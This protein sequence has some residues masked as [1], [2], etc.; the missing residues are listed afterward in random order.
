[1]NRRKF[2]KLL[3]SAGTSTAAFAACS[4]YMQEALAQSNVVNTLL[5]ASCPSPK[6]SLKDIEHVILFMQENRSFDHYFGTLRGVRGFG[7]PRPLLLQNG[8]QVWEQPIKAGT[9]QT[10][11][12]YH[13]VGTVQL[14][15]E[16]GAA[17]IDSETTAEAGRAF[18]Q[19]P[20]HGHSDSV[21]AW[22]CGR[23]DGWVPAKNVVTLAHYVEQDL[24]LYF[25]LAK[26]FTVCDANFCSHNGG[27]DSNRSFYYTGT[28]MGRND[29]SY[30]SGN[31]NAASAPNWPSYP[32]RLETLGVDWRFYQDGLHWT[33][34]RPFDG[35]YGDNTLEYFQQ[36]QDNTTS[37]FKKNQSINSVLRTSADV[38]SR[39]EQDIIDAKLPA[40]SWIVAPEAFS[41]H[42]TFPPHLGEYYLNEILRCLAANPEVWRKTVLITT[43]DEN[44][45]FFDHVPPP[46]PPLNANQGL[47]SSGIR[48]VAAPDGASSA[49]FD[50]D[51]DIEN[52]IDALSAP[53][54]MGAR[55]P[56]LVISP[57]STGGRVCSEVF[58]HTSSI[59]FVEAWLAAKGVPVDQQPYE[60]I[61]MWRMA[62]AGD[63][64]SAL[65]FNQDPAPDMTA[66]VPPLTTAEIF[67]D[68]QKKV[69][70][71]WAWTTELVPGTIGPSPDN[72][73]TVVASKQETAQVEL[74]PLGYEFQVYSAFVIPTGG[75]AERLQFTFRNAGQLGVPYS[76]YVYSSDAKPRFYTVEGVEQG[77]DPITLSDSMD[78]GGGAYHYVVHAPNGYLA[79][80][81]GNRS[82]P[83]QALFPEVSA[84]HALDDAKTAQVALT[85]WPSANGALKLIDAY[86]GNNQNLPAGTQIASIAT[87]D[88]WYDLALVDASGQ[89]DFLR[90]YSGHFE[91]GKISKTDPAIGKVYD[92]TTY[93]YQQPGMT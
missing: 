17:P 66:L 22:N 89:T 20:P 83:V 46:T 34:G 74:L 77:S 61:S 78:L 92:A 45:G 88:G 1:M 5:D 23:M 21:D 91:N 28:A 35:N 25:K 43:F 42:P 16:T 26:A 85:A 36:Y 64:T 8:T 48:I 12:P 6:G 2:I 15:N 68:E 7:D 71:A 38:P 49:S 11:K 90:R 30:F 76:L 75:G 87:H 50:G 39:F 4:A 53:T 31:N 14:N 63:L 65:D 72:N 58:D 27:T 24:P 54:G 41:E 55:V 33:S 18:I 3:R 56:M 62:V 70:N 52:S 44:G 69:I 73:A 84:I 57:W 80:F 37:I 67:T 59:N 51:V 93:T 13:F 81:R 79:E 40:V 29:N 32:E 19:D 9:P 60:Q 82:E 47:V 10:A 86:T